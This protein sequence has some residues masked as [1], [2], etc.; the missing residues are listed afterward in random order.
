MTEELDHSK[1]IEAARRL[2]ENPSAQVMCPTCGLAFLTMRDERVDG[3]HI[4]RRLSCPN[5]GAH[6]WVLKRVGIVENRI[7][8]L[9]KLDC[10]PLTRSQLD[11]SLSVTRRIASGPASQEFSVTD[12]TAE[13]VPTKLSFLGI[14]DEDVLVCWPAFREGFKMKWS[15]FVAHL[16]DLWYPGSDDV[17]V[18]SFSRAWVLEITHEEE[19]RFYREAGDPNDWK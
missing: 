10:A 1:W 8:S 9:S 12:L 17:M 7:R 18:I 19:V 5:C 4:D 16:P 11:E 15:A 14:V 13:A 3:E 6:E 2:T